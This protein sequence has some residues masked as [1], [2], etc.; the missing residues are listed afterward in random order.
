MPPDNKI[1]NKNLLLK[2]ELWV[3]GTMKYEMIT[4]KPDIH[5]PIELMGQYLHHLSD[6][7]M[8][9]YGDDLTYIAKTTMGEEKWTLGNDYTTINVS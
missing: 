3:G 7:D 1:P 9:L 4:H 6:M 2:I 5:V 8:I